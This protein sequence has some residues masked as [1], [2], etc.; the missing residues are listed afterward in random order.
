VI[1]LE[2]APGKDALREYATLLGTPGNLPDGTRL[3]MASAE[4]AAAVLRV[5]QSD[6]PVMSVQVTG[7]GAHQ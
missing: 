5:V 1:V 6:R 3:Y 7:E 2:L 4:S